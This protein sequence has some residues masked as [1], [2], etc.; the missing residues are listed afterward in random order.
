MTPRA[1]TLCAAA[2]VAASVLS[3]C[4]GS[5]NA[6]DGGANG[7]ASDDTLTFAAIP[8]EQNADPKVE[9]AGTTAAIEKATGKKV[10]VIK[11]T[12][13]NAVIEGML[14]G[15]VDIA[16]FG[17]LS[18]VLAK[19]NGAKITPVAAMIEEKGGEATYK[20]LGLAPADSDIDSLK[21]YR[22]KNVC[23]VDPASTSGYL[24]PTTAL[25]DAGIDP[26]KDIKPVMAGGHDASA[27]AIK[28]GQCDAG[29]AYDGM[30]N[31]LIASGDLKKNDLKVVWQ[32]DPIPQSPV[33]VQD[34]L[35]A[36]LKKQITDGLLKDAN[37]DAM[38]ASGACSNVE[39]CNATGD[40]T[41]WGYAATDDATYDTVRKVCEVT[42][43]E[44]CTG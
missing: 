13:Y 2:V 25:N 34:S 12:D 37:K 18:Y 28:D 21:D 31:Q 14:A 17:P 36:T 10:E 42:K 27:L 6:S 1:L 22:G 24:F 26:K 16:S 32:S 9:F 29:F 33:A 5:S 11:A 35:P 4:G 19:N 15:D 23:F 44:E 39:D 30:V 3:A 40:A 20:S 7:G 43:N 41:Y 38:V 8:A